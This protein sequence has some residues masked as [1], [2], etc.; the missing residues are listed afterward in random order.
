MSRVFDIKERYDTDADNLY[1]YRIRMGL[2][3]GLVIGCMKHFE[4][5]YHLFIF[6]KKNEGQKKMT[7][8]N[9]KRH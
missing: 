8:L 4:H 3:L 2:G 6:Q 9:L 1:V 7:F 5:F